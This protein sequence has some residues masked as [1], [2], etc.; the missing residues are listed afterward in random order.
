MTPYT[1]DAVIN[2]PTQKSIMTA[3]KQD[4][5]QRGHFYEDNALESASSKHRLVSDETI[6]MNEAQRYEALHGIE[7][8]QPLSETHVVHSV[9]DEIQ[10][11]IDLSY[12]YLNNDAFMAVL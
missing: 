9:R 5:E 2:K 7:T 10:N 8:N 6:Q 4:F 3:Q 1:L 11:E 12:Y